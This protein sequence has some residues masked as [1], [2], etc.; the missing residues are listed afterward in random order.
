MD[1]NQN[2][3]MS[4]MNWRNLVSESLVSPRRAA[5]S[6]IDLGLSR[7]LL[8]QA[9]AAV[10]ALGVVLGF[11]AV[12]LG[13]GDI[14]QVSAAIVTNPLLGAALQFGIVLLIAFMT[15]R[16]GALFGGTG[17]L[18][19]ALAIVVLLNSMMLLIQLVQLAAMLLVPPLATFVAVATIVWAFWAFSSFV[20]ELHGFQNVAFVLGGVFLSM[21]VLFF[22]LAMI[23]AILGFT[24]PQEGM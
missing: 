24:P 21:I 20:A 11:L 23:L 5:R 12:F 17:T 16:I 9:A 14:D 8:V 7:D 18:D 6:V 10:T 1:E 13:T 3:G 19:G 15:A 2:Q 4:A 22:G